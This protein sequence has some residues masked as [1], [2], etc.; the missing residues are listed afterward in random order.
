VPRPLALLLAATVATTGCSSSSPAEPTP[1]PVAAPAPDPT[2]APAPVPPTPMTGVTIEYITPDTAVAGSVFRVVALGSGGTKPY[3]F[4]FIWKVDGGPHVIRDWSVDPTYSV[5][6]FSDTT[7]EYEVWGRSWSFDADAPQAS[8]NFKLT[9][10]PAPPDGPITGI[11]VSSNV[12]SPQSV[13]TTIV[14]TAHPFAGVKPYQVKWLVNGATVQD[15]TT[16]LNW[17]WVPQSSSLYTIE[18]WG[19]SAGAT[20]DVSQASSRFPF[21]IT[22]K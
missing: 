3:Q 6:M 14:F 15:W 11:T 20:A 8:A 16:N 5:Q 4:K 22:L 18:V 17:T 12:L 9:A 10:T 2:P 19:R 21:T 7:S 13:G 1:T